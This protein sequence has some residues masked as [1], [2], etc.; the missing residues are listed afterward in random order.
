MSTHGLCIPIGRMYFGLITGSYTR[1]LSG[2]VLRKAMWSVADEVNQQFGTFN[3]TDSSQRGGII[4]TLNNLRIID[5]TYDGYYYSDWDGTTERCAWITDKALEEGHCRNWGNPI[6]EMMHEALRYLAGRTSPTS[7]YLYATPPNDNDKGLPLPNVPWLRTGGTQIRPPYEIFPICS[8]PFMIV[9][10]D[11]NNSYDSDSVPGSHFASFSGDLIALN[12]STLANS[13]STGEGISGNYFIGQSSFYD[14]ICSSKNVSS[15]A[16]I[17]GLCP[18]EPTKQGSFYPAS[19]AYYGLRPDGWRS[20]FLGSKPPP[21]ETFSVA[22]ASPVPDINVKVGNR[23]VRITPIGKSVSGCLGVHT[24]CASRC[25]LTRDATGNLRITD[26]QSGSYC[27]S[28]QIVDLYVEQVNYD[29]NNNL[30]YAS[31][32]IN[33]ED[34][35]QGADHDM[36]AVVR[37]IIQPVGSNQIKVRLEG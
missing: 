28:N 34:V 6:A 26:C 15:L 17:R 1:N 36:D 30:T 32:S 25:T 19:I 9:I 4:R 20:N 21:V 5:F 12:V 23:F 18:E 37:Y 11:I 33:Y 8:R 3:S 22:L 14:F 16:T 27:T 35:E 31:F 29:A 24:A 13:I 7:A 2:G 10:S